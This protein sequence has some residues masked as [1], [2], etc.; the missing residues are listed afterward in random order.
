[1]ETGLRP[2]EKLYEELLI[3]NRDIEKT[4]NE[5]IFV[6]HQPPITPEELAE[7]L[8][9][10]RQA[11]AQEDPTAIRQVLHRVVPTF[12]EPDELNRC[13]GQTVTVPEPAQVK[14]V[15]PQ[16]AATK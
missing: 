10:L 8:T 9:L 3:A 1:M 15:D 5:M 7:K 16:A 4:S 6:E 14:S 13:Q 12:H 11:L 2:G